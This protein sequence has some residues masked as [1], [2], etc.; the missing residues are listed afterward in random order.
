MT[1]NLRLF[2]VVAIVGLVVGPLMAGGL[3]VNATASSPQSS[4]A[5]AVIQTASAA[6][7]S[8][9]VRTT[10]SAALV[11][12]NNVS[13]AIPNNGQQ[14][15]IAAN[16]VTPGISGSYLVALPPAS[17]N[18]TSISNTSTMAPFASP[19]ATANSTASHG[20]F[21]PGAQTIVVD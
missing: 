21:S 14:A 6:F 3:Y 2:V 16:N 17:G 1:Q 9:I 12:I 18:A 4:G 11:S 19:G 10:G 5:N 20:G 15:V 13:A 8:P 7:V